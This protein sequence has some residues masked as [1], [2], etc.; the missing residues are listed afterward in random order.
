MSYRMRSRMWLDTRLRM[1]PTLHLRCRR[2]RG[3]P[4]QWR[5][6]S[7]RYTYFRLSVGPRRLLD[8]TRARAVCVFFFWQQSYTALTTSPRECPDTTCPPLSCQTSDPTLLVQ[9]PLAANTAR[10][11]WTFRNAFTCVSCEFSAAAVLGTCGLSWR[12]GNGFGS[13]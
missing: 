12:R 9:F 3:S 2:Q 7:G 10:A 5:G 11:P 4:Y 8:G 13:R 6:R 1:M